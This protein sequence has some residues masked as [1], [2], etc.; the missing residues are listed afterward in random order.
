MRSAIGQKLTSSASALNLPHF[1]LA[2]APPPRPKHV[3][4]I[5]TKLQVEGRTRDLA[6]FNIASWLMIPRPSQWIIFAKITGGCPGKEWLQPDRKTASPTDMPGIS[7][8][9]PTIRC[10]EPRLAFGQERSIIS[11][12][13]F[14]G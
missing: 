13:G 5:R 11:E 6:L 10:A 12:R 14:V 4:S 8:H 1:H 7:P 9:V 3:W 2:L